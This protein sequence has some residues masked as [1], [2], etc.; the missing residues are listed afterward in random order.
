MVPTLILGSHALAALLFA[1]LALWAL[2]SEGDGSLPRKPL[3][4]ALA[5]TAL[6]ALAVAGIGEND[7]VT[8]IAQGARN[9]GW[10]AFMIVVQRRGG[11]ER[12]PAAIGTVYGVV[13][14]VILVKLA[15]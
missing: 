3:A 5:M 13:A 11:T 7:L 10:L 12:P 6:W 14:V 1:S 2:R 9:L 4:A 8:R 15:L